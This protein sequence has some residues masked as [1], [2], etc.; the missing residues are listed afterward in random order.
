MTSVRDAFE[1]MAWGPAPESP[2]HAL[3]WL[4]KHHRHFGQYV[5]GA[6][7]RNGSESF[8][9]MNPAT[10][11]D[12]ARVAQAGR[13]EVDAAVGA[14]RAAQPPWWQLGGHG[15]ARWLYALAREIQRNARLFAVVES[16][17]NGK[18]IRE[19]R[20]I[21]IP[22]VA[23]HFYYHAGWAQLMATELA[24]YEPV[25]VIGQIIPW[26]FPLL[27][28]AWKIAPALAMSIETIILEGHLS[29]REL[30]DRLAP[31]GHRL[32]SR[33][34]WRRPSSFRCAVRPR[35]CTR[36]GTRSASRRCRRGG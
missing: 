21:D 18:P 11:E 7:S 33:G 15:R 31:I 22:L 19:S 24:G 13:A 6:W 4:E 28:L 30:I 29:S 12:L 1:S 5:N 23:R 17:D 10:R 34:G 26:N 20:D 36:S 3:A 14:A 9:V 16:L 2:A 25:G 8:A 32:R 35:T 27:M